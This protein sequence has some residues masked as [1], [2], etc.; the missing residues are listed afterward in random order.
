MVNAIFL[1]KVLKLKL[2]VCTLITSWLFHFKSTMVVDKIKKF[3]KNSNSIIVQIITEVQQM[4]MQH[5]NDCRVLTQTYTQTLTFLLRF[6]SLFF[7]NSSILIWAPYLQDQRQDKK[8]KR[9]LEPAL[10]HLL[11][12][13]SESPQTAGILRNCEEVSWDNEKLPHLA[14]LE[15]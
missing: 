1:V 15:R 8:K 10:V 7:F 14:D 4:M 6:C 11:S 5:L 9:N 3:K 13:N 2:K 12:K